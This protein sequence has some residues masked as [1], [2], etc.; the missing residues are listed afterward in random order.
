MLA[1]IDSVFNLR[2][3]LIVAVAVNLMVLPIIL[4]YF[5]RFSWLSIFMTVVLSPLMPMILFSIAMVGILPSW[6]Y[7]HLYFLFSGGVNLLELQVK[8]IGA[9]SEIQILTVTVAKNNIN[10]FYL[11]LIIACLYFFLRKKNIK[12]GEDGAK[13]NNQT[14]KRSDGMQDIGT[15][16]IEWQKQLQL[17]CQQYKNKTGQTETF[18]NIKKTS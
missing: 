16:L 15:Y 12:I 6:I 14:I 5:G 2:T 10:F 3:G 13:Q 9:F 18:N 1:K 7:G 17:R 8:M 4:Y 11:Y